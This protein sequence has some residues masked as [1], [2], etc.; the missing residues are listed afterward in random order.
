MSKER[1]YPR[2]RTPDG[3]VKIERS[4][5]H[6]GH[7]IVRL[8]DISKAGLAFETL[9]VSP[10]KIGEKILIVETPTYDMRNRWSVVRHISPRKNDENVDIHVVGVEFVGTELL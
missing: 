1:Q 2:T 6:E 9:T 7:Q 4:V 5:S 3:W 10:Y 8:S